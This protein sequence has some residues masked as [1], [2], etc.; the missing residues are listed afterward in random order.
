MIGLKSGRLTVVI[1]LCVP[2]LSSDSLQASSWIKTCPDDM[3][4]S[5]QMDH[6]ASMDEMNSSSSAAQI[7]TDVFTPE[8]SFDPAGGSEGIA[9][10]GRLLAQCSDTDDSGDC[11]GESTGHWTPEDKEEVEGQSSSPSPK[12]RASGDVSHQPPPVFSCKVCGE[13]FQKLSYLFT[14]SSAHLKDCSLC[15]KHLEPAETLKLH[16]KVHREASFRCSECG[17]SFTLRGNLRTHMRIHSGE[18]PY[19]CTVCD[20]SFGRRATLVRHVRSHTGEKPFGCTYCGRRFV[21]KGNLTV[22]L[23]THTGERPYWCSN[24]D[25]RFS[26]LASFYKHPCQR[27]SLPKDIMQSKPPS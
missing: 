15:G 12:Q 16:L 24:C 17:Q 13:S 10:D 6:S 14:H 26:Q 27:R 1:C 19:T 8:T 21:E 22:H 9:G 5:G 2:R 18:R 7:K 11:W 23:R 25:R 20:K 4:P 3:T